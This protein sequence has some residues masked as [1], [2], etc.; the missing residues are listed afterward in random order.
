MIDISSV[1]P[2]RFG[3]AGKTSHPDKCRVGLY[4]ASWRWGR[5][6]GTTGQRLLL[7]NTRCRRT[8]M[9]DSGRGG[10]RRPLLVW[11]FAKRE[12]LAVA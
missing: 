6:A 5:F 12:R 10:S 3:L 9:Y 7:D 4:E 2:N 8:Y 11:L 1:A